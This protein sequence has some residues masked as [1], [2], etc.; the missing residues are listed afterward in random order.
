MLG[1]TLKDLTKKA[2]KHVK[3]GVVLKVNILIQG[4]ILIYGFTS[5]TSGLVKHGAI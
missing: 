1:L 4:H 2:K 3:E 5:V